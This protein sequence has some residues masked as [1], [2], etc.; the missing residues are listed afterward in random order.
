MHK[1]Q[2]LL[3]FA[4]IILIWG[5]NWTVTKLIILSVPPIWSTAIRSLIAAT[6][7]LAL[8]ILTRQFIIPKWHD[9]PAILVISIFHMVL[10]GL[11]MA[12]GLQYASVGRSVILGYTTPLWVIPAAVLI[13]REP[14][15]P[16]RVVGVIFGILGVVILFYPIGQP[17]GNA[18]ELFGNSILLAASFAWAVTIIFIK[19][20]KWLSTPF[21]LVF[22]QNLLA[23]VLL[24]VIA[25]F[26]EGIPKV[27]PNKNLIWQFAYS[28]LLATAFGFW[29]MTV[30]N[31]YLP[32]VV[33]SLGS[34]AT[35]I[36]GIACSQIVL[37]EKIDM[38]LLI[39]AGFILAG[40]TFSCISLKTHE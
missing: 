7:L 36:V 15:N 24:T 20:Y 39:A 33:T 40:I 38:Q 37:G 6:A 35:P 25:L 26:I 21:Q 27:T 28:G 19:S 11:L 16:L 23:F 13:L 5:V 9:I 29:G 1:R 30:I 32:A 3:L 17:A 14:I 8:Q 10:F 2:A 22:W 31:K 4:V 12:I 34:L 18:S